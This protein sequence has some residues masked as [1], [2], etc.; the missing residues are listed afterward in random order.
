MASS[1]ELI[2]QVI[3]RMTVC[4]TVFNNLVLQKFARPSLMW[5]HNLLLALFLQVNLFPFWYY[6]LN[7]QHF[8][9]GAGTNF[10][11]KGRKLA[12]QLFSQ[13][14][15]WFIA[16]VCQDFVYVHSNW[17][18]ASRTMRVKCVSILESARWH[19]R[20]E[21]SVRIAPGVPVFSF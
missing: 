15:I 17:L 16:V 10:H 20:P 6:I 8:Y 11:C 21:E 5:S 18:R 3:T 4:K 12:E 13:F 9:I 2:L 14:I 1:A 19:S 7:Y